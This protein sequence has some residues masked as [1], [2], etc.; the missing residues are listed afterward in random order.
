MG[1]RIE[2]ACLNCN[3]TF[4]LTSDTFIKSPSCIYCKCNDQEKLKVLECKTFTKINIDNS[5]RGK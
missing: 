2:Y 5:K 1:I 4:E 3:K